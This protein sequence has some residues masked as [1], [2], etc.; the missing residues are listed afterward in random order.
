[1]KRST[2][3]FLTLSAA[4]IITSMGT[5]FFGVRYAV[6]QIPPETRSQME[7]TDWIGFEWIERGMAIFIVAIVVGSVPVVRELL[8][9]R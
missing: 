2:Q 9:K 8:K 5:C 4:L 1:M 3:I 6:N 7:D